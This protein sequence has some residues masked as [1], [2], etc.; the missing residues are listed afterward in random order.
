MADPGAMELRRWNLLTG[1]PLAALKLITGIPA[2]KPRISDEQVASP[3]GQPLGV[4]MTGSLCIAA[5]GS[6]QV[7]S[8]K[9]DRKTCTIL[10]PAFDGKTGRLRRTT[11]VQSVPFASVLGAKM[12]ELSRQTF[13]PLHAFGIAPR[14]GAA[15][16]GIALMDQF[17]IRD[18]AT[19]KLIRTLFSSDAW[20]GDF[21]E[22]E[23]SPRGDSI[24][25]GRGQ[26]WNISTGKPKPF[27]AAR[28]TQTAFPSIAFAR[29]A[30][31]GP[32]L[33]VALDSSHGTVTLT[34]AVS[35]ARLFTMTDFGLAKGK[36]T[37]DQWLSVT[38]DGHYSGSPGIEKM[39]RWRVEH[40]LFPAEKFA[41]MMRQAP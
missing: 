40:E 24:A 19:G 39:F 6:V 32:D 26:M 27:P 17:Q 31:D 14:P 20:N 11:V 13:I 1:K 37:G 28:V 23:F 8:E 7:L 9:S 15:Q 38:P 35:G 22:F 12:I 29:A 18:T 3:L 2:P 4:E 41:G 21:V 36:T 16:V 34:D 25:T 5:D 33:F 30:E 10:L